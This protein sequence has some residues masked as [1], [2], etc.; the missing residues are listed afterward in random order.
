MDRVSGGYLYD[1]MVSAGL[2]SRGVRVDTLA[3]SKPPYLLSIFQSLSPR[4]RDVFRPSRRR[5]NGRGKYD[6]VIVD[7]LVHPSVCFALPRRRA[8]GGSVVTLLHHLKSKERIPPLLRFVSSF[9]ERTLLRRSNMVVANSRTTSDTVRELAVRR[10]PVRVCRPGKDALG[11]GP[12]DM[13]ERRTAR[14][15]V[16]IL[17][18][19]TLIPRKGFHLLIPAIEL[20]KDLDCAL[21]IAG[22]TGTDRTY[23]RKIEEM[24]VKCGLSER[25]T[26][27]GAV[28]EKDLV[29]LYR[30]SH[31]FAF[32]TRYEGY[33]IVLAEALFFGLPYVAFNSGAIAEVVGLYEKRASLAAV[34]GDPPGITRAPGGYLVSDHSV[35]ELARGLRL[36]IEKR[37]ER[38]ELEKEAGKLGSRLPSWEDTALCFY[39]TLAGFSTDAIRTEDDRP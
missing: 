34:G 16:R 27:A 10:V 38:K 7:E 9:L 2:T 37:E 33:G 18:V 5:A 25:V 22:G 1:R 21:T 32:P 29:R 24:I 6:F 13:M 12:G 11:S 8:G 35:E 39:E 4:I 17:S 30:S 14:G 26:L 28:P 20:I 19:G 3:L 15:T 31:I 36:L 23:T